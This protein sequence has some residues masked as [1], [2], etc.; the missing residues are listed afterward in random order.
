[1]GEYLGWEI[2]KNEFLWLIDSYVRQ[3]LG[4]STDF[5]G[6]TVNYDPGDAGALGLVELPGEEDEL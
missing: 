3:T 2:T 4:H 1:M 5:E 6:I